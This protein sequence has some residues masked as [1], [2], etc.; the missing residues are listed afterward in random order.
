MCCREYRSHSTLIYQH[1]TSP[2]VYKQYIQNPSNSL[3]QNPANNLHRVTTTNSNTPIYKPNNMMRTSTTSNNIYDVPYCNKGTKY[4]AVSCT[5]PYTECTDIND[6][7]GS[8]SIYSYERS[9]FL[10]SSTGSSWT[11]QPYRQDI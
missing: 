11:S 10:M 4:T 6:G 2:S 8:S 1:Q 3:P 9:R 7:V 5:E